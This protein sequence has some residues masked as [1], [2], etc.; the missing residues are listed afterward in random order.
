M[1][2]IIKTLMIVITLPISHTQPQGANLPTTLEYI[3]LYINK[4]PPRWQCP[5]LSSLMRR[6]LLTGRFYLLETLR[7]VEIL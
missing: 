2:A 7:M 4:K 1:K 3:N 5:E 6:Y